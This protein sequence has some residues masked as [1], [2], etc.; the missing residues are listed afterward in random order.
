MKNFRMDIEFRNKG[1]VEFEE[2]DNTRSFKRLKNML[3]AFI[4]ILGLMESL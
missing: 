3:W 2:L 1:S 4:L